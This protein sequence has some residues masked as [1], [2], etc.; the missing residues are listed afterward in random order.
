MV[1]IFDWRQKLAKYVFFHFLHWW[2]IE[3]AGFRFA[4]L[5]KLS[6]GLLQRK[7]LMTLHIDWLVA[8][9]WG[10]LVGL[11]VL[12]SCFGLVARMEAC[13]CWCEGI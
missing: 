7:G 3:K 5:M 6:P 1:H 10:C 13:C 12:F 2:R 11:L 4:G 8:C 9:W